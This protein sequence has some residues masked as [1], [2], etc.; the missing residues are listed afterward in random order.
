MTPLDEI[1][2]AL[3]LIVAPGQVFELR[4]PKPLQGGGVVAG[5]F[6]NIGQGA[7]A[8]SRL[9]GKFQGV[10]V[11]LNPVD[12]TLL[13][14][15]TNKLKRSI[16]TT[17]DV[18]I[19]RRRWL[20]IDL[21]PI[22]PSDVSSNEDEHAAAIERARRVRDWLTDQEWPAPVLA[23]SGNGAHLLYRVDLPNSELATALVKNVLAALSARFSDGA[24]KLDTGVYNAARIWKVYGTLSAKGDNVPLRPHRRASVLEA[25]QAPADVPPDLIQRLA[26][27][28]PRPPASPRARSARTTAPADAANRYVQKVLTDELAA[29]RNAPPDEANNNLFK[30][31]AHLF[32]FVACG[33][34]TDNEVE[35][36][37]MDAALARGQ[38]VREARATIASGRKHGM[39][40]P[41]H[42]PGLN[43]QPQNGGGDV[44]AVL[45]SINDASN[46]IEK[47]AAVEAGIKALAGLSVVQFDAA[48]AAI[49]AAVK[50]VVRGS[51]IDEMVKQMRASDKQLQAA[52]SR[53]SRNDGQPYYRIQDGELWAGRGPESHPV[54]IG[55]AARWAEMVSVDDGGEI[56]R[57]LTL[58]VLVKGGA[59]VQTRVKS[60]DSGDVTKMVAAIRGAVGYKVSLPPNARGLLCLAIDEISREAAREVNEISRTGWFERDGQ[61]AFVTPGG[62]VGELPEGYRV[63]LK[64]DFNRFAVVDGDDESYRLGIEGLLNGFGKGFDKS[65]SY[66]AL[67]FALLP[68]AARWLPTEGRRIWMHFSGE[69]GTNKTTV[70][71]CLMA[72]YG[73]EFAKTNPLAS[74]RG[75][76]NS[77]ERMGWFLPD[78]LGLVDEYKPVL[79]KPRDF[80]DMCH[81]YADGTDRTRLTSRADLHARKPPRWW[82]IST[83]EDVPPGESSLMARMIVLRFP[84]RPVGAP[85]NAG[86]A[87]MCRLSKHFPVVTARWAKWLMAH[88]DAFDFA[89]R[90]ERHHQPIATYVQ[91]A[92]PTAPNVNRIA[93]N[94]ALIW[95]VWEAW[96]QCLRDTN[97]DIVSQPKA[98]AMSA[99]FEAV[100]LD[101]AFAQAAE[102]VEQ[103]P[104]AV[105]LEAVQEG[106]DAGEFVL[107]HRNEPGENTALK[108]IA[109]WHDD[110]GIYLLPAL[111]DR[112]AT[113]KFQSQRP[114]GFSRAELYRLLR[115]EGLLANSDKNSTTVKIWVGAGKNKQRRRVLHLRPDA[116]DPGKATETAQA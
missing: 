16:A 88:G 46:A 42:P 57:E 48:S 33:H 5:Y 107:F 71:Q 35:A 86:L 101:I 96:W 77:I 6:N 50:G 14:R 105:F 40:N 37:L 28:A 10:Y 24:V 4:A 85:Y 38:S 67:A 55:G 1:S 95:A 81:R 41:R 30:A 79:V 98:D 63:K 22:R 3:Q 113:R 84:R 59:S 44:A 56:R 29:V 102:A 76:S 91:N 110:E 114:L 61:L 18:D 87:K 116:L 39:A 82:V 54:L 104:T 90:V 2:R 72:L 26:D 89:A 27:Q 66:P 19:A 51:A 100:A 106:I 103:K 112:I 93:R 17:A 47:A 20:P 31:S 73:A 13:A 34:L 58:E 70:A 12:A 62:I 75:S 43:A 25:P 52:A 64:D 7:E 9:D 111:Y 115:E 15:A 68:V 109:G 83:G 21:D 32:S 49:K 94:V 80:V 74:F 23:D 45:A 108:T 78:C 99:A 60:E 69:T 92:V 53:A 97:P 65:I 36:A 8:A 11:T